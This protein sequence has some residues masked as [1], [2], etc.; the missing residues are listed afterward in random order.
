MT[1]TNNDKNRQ[2]FETIKILLLLKQKQKK[3][4]K[5][6]KQNIQNRNRSYQKKKI[7]A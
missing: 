6:T 3:Q 1:M 4:K 2:I 7:S 5:E